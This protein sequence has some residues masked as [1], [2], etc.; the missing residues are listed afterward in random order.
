MKSAFRDDLTVVT[1]PPGTGK[2]QIVTTVIANAWMRQQSVLFASHNHKAVDVVEERVN[3]LA[4]K[5]LMI[6]TGRRAR[7]RELRNEISSYLANVLASNVTEQDRQDLDDARAGVRRL[8]HDRDE[9][10][11][12]LEQLRHQRNR[13]DRIDREITSFRSALDDLERERD[14]ELLKLERGLSDIEKRKDAAKR[15]REQEKTSLD[16]EIESIQGDIETLNRERD[17][18]KRKRDV[19]IDAVNHELSAMRVY[20]DDLH[21]IRSGGEI[22]N[23]YFDNG[24]KEIVKLNDELESLKRKR[25]IETQLR[26]SNMAPLG[27]QIDRLGLEFDPRMW[28][29]QNRHNV[30]A[31][32]SVIR[33]ALKIAKAQDIRAGSI[34]GL[35]LRQ[36]TRP[37]HFRRVSGLVRTWFNAYDLLGTPPG[38]SLTAPTL[39]IWIDYLTDALAKLSEWEHL[40]ERNKGL[41]SQ[42]EELESSRDEIAAEFDDLGFDQRIANQQKVIHER[43]TLHIE[44]IDDRIERHRQMVRDLNDAFDG[45]LYEERITELH[46]SIQRLRDDHETK[47]D[48]RI[49][50]LEESRQARILAF[51]DMAF[52]KRLSEVNTELTSRSS[53]FNQ[54]VESLSNGSTVNGLAEE[55]R[56]VEK[57]VWDAGKHLIGASVRV[58]PD[59]IDTGRRRSIGDFRALFERLQNDQLGGAAYAELMAEMEALFP[60]VMAMLPSWCVTNLSAR[61]NIPLHDGLFDL[62]VIDEAS[63]C[64]IPSALP[65]LYRAKRALIIGDPNQLRHITSINGR[66]DQI[67]QEKHGLHAAADATLAFSQNSLFDAAERNASPRQLNEH[68]RSHADIIGFSNQHWYN[69]RLLVCTDYNDLHIPTGQEPGIRWHNVNGRVERS[70]TLNGNINRREAEELSKQVIDLIADRGFRGSV[71]I[72]T[73]FRAQANL[74]RSI[75]N[76]RLE[77]SDVQ[78]CDLITDTAH[79][80]QGDE[81]DV[82]FFSPCVEFQMPS[83][84]EWF[85]GETGNLFNVAITRARS[86]LV[87]V[88][89]LEACLA[90]RITHVKGFAEFCD[91]TL[92]GRMP[93]PIHQTLS[94]AQPSA[95]GNAPSMRLCKPLD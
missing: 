90:S 85:I 64:D 17:V 91:K 1:G 6:R 12:K 20:R 47:H 37:R 77:P 18:A 22:T 36:F 34:W 68:F 35:I 81:K 28:E 82:V 14:V 84:A 72:V 94:T 86:L 95:T 25:E 60:K 2:S 16:A 27:Q 71:G 79:A 78:R 53:E 31:Y 45:L 5:P 83:G 69:D 66:R 88:G 41:K 24:F 65:L 40:S 29:R 67:L 23:E 13:I 8:E 61:G 11:V 9:I 30:S 44:S 87:V 51:D 57:L 63:Q 62:V 58:M 49:V 7:D 19:E 10:W 73:P 93:Q 74:I 55:L 56:E 26:N 76:Q 80:F 39:H 21:R 15:A 92:K 33:D 43:V 48:A 42:I 54:A 52:A 70:S 59:R 46:R 4:S 50:E 3:D 75:I 32:R 89:N 38:G